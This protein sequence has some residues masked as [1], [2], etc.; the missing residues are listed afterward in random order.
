MKPYV[1]LTKEESQ[2]LLDRIARLETVNADLED[3]LTD[4][5]KSINNLRDEI[6]RLEAVNAELVK[7]LE[8][9]KETIHTWHDIYVPDG[10]D[11]WELYQDSPEM[12]T[13]NAALTL[14]QPPAEGEAC[15]PSTEPVQ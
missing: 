14:A 3:G 12:K 5:G 10:R 1:E 13:I 15:V 6:T 9:A 8:R 2:R 4:Q 11:D 7:T